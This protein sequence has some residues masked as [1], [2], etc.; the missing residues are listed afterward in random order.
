MTGLVSSRSWIATL[1][2]VESVPK[3]PSK[4]VRG[5]QLRHHGD[6]RAPTS[7]LGAKVNGVG[8]RVSCTL[9]SNIEHVIRCGPTG[10]SSRQASTRHGKSVMSSWG[11]RAA[12][13][14]V[15][16][17]T[18]RADR[19]TGSLVPVLSEQFRHRLGRSAPPAEIRSWERSLSVPVGGP[20]RGGPR[21]C[22]GIGG[23]SAP[24]D[25]QAGRRDPVRH[26]I[27]GRGSRRTWWSSSSSG[28]AHTCWT[29]PTRSASSTG[30]ASGSI[31]SSRSG[32]TARYLADFAATPW[33][34]IPSG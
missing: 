10:A 18:A 32:A 21:T 23:V 34:I 12:L 19:L 5:G 11:R 7:R 24:S 3:R 26:C 27:R 22:R 6:T 13:P 16:G 8:R 9:V 30:W 4:D 29:A 25:Q 15:R 20:G 28:A 17:A 31:P 1:V 33:P 2:M 14:W